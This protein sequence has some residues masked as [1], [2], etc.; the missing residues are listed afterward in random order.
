ML[1]RQA[2]Q[3]EAERESKR[4]LEQSLRVNEEK[5]QLASSDFSL[6]L[7]MLEEQVTKVEEEKSE[8]TQKLQQSELKQKEIMQYVRQLQ[9]QENTE[10]NQVRAIL[11]DRLS[12]EQMGSIKQKEKSAALFTEVVRLGE[13]QNK[14]EEEVQ[15]LHLAIES[16]IQTF[17]EKISIN[18]KLI[19]NLEKLQQVGQNTSGRDFER[20]LQ[21]LDETEK[22]LMLLSN[23]SQ[24]G[25]ETLSRLEVV[26]LKHNE[27]FKSMLGNMQ[28][29]FAG[30][31]SGQI[32]D[33]VGKILN[34]Q[35]SRNRAIEDIRHQ[36]EMKER[37]SEERVRQENE[38]AQERYNSMDLKVAA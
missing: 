27:D 25:K 35:D 19:S 10:M 16:R 18:E 17:E 5:S 30:R 32:T 13:T 24:K 34:E 21:R 4:R 28:A 7:S 2:Q 20:L 3:L 31:L 15:K 38:K 23:E 9:Q 1:H 33:L 37:F 14:T 22:Q 26:S 11:Q 36:V 12:E 6:R 29:E 8:L